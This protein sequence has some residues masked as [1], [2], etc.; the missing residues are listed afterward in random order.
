MSEPVILPLHEALDQ[1]V[2]AVRGVLGSDSMTGMLAKHLQDALGEMVATMDDGAGLVCPQCGGNGY[3]EVMSDGGPD[4]YEVQETCDHCGGKQTLADAYEGVLKLLKAE[5]E[6]YREACAILWGYHGDATVAS[7]VQQISDWL[8]SCAEKG[9]W[10]EYE[11]GWA[12]DRLKALADMATTA[13]QPRPDAFKVLR[14]GTRTAVATAD[15]EHVLKITFAS[16]AEMIAAQYELSA[17][18]KWPTQ[19]QGKAE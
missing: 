18:L 5:T 3:I 12:V 16:S 17:A 10:G 9:K 19:A 2:Q 8:T 15:G 4:A 1:L 7:K 14:N 13:A 11:R 6:K